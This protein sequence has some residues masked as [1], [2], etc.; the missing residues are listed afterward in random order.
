MEKPAAADRPGSTQATDD[1]EPD[2]HRH[3]KVQ[4]R[5]A[6]REH[7]V[8]AEAG[9]IGARC[10]A[11][12]PLQQGAVAQRSQQQGDDVPQNKPRKRRRGI[13]ENHC[14]GDRSGEQKGGPA[15]QQHGGGAEPA[16]YADHHEMKIG[17]ALRRRQRQAEGDQFQR[18]FGEQ[19]TAGCRPEPA[20]VR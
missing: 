7:A 18:Q 20:R 13:A 16:G 8:T 10:Q 12:S 6:G 1:D 15:D 14:A 17:D 5:S 19:A 3:G 11:R 4:H 2:H 9:E